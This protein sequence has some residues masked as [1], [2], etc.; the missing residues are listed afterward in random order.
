MSWTVILGILGIVAVGRRE[1]Q[2]MS[3]IFTAARPPV[4]HLQCDIVVRVANRRR[5]RA[6][7][8][9][10]LRVSFCRACRINGSFLT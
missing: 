3:S 6:R 5:R 7:I 4:P 1:G 2:G 8:S 10:S 9:S